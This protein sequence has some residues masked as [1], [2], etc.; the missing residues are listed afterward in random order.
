MQISTALA[1]FETQLHADGRS[2][3]TVTSYLR[4]LRLLQRWLAGQGTPDPDVAQITPDDLARFVLSDLVTKTA[5]GKP[6]GR[7]AINQVKSAVRVFFRYLEE[8]GELQRNPA[9]ALRVKYPGRTVPQVLD[10]ED[11]ARLLATIG[12][13]SGAAAERDFVIVSMFLGTG[14]RLSS[15]VGIDVGDVRLADRRMVI[16]GKGGRRETVVLSTKLA[17]LLAGFIGDREDGPLFRSA[18]GGRI[19][20]RQVQY[21]LEGWCAAAA[22]RRVTPHQLRHGFATRLYRHTKDL[23]VVQRSLHHV[24]ISS[25]EIYVRVADEELEAAVEAI[26]S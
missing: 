18:R 5:A 19:S 10:D 3:H 24:H 25:T 7:I 1:R 21:R 4:A 13:G 11:Q 16:T 23:R 22:V 6:K 2:R 26:V 20:V 14:V 12:E 8:T 15:L 9:R 17:A